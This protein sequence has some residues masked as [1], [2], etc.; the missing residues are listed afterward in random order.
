MSTS[1]STRMEE[2]MGIG[3]SMKY[4][5]P[6][7]EQGRSQAVLK[8]TTHREGST[9]TWQEEL[10]S[11]K[12][13]LVNIHARGATTW[14]Q[15]A[16]AKEGQLVKRDTWCYARDHGYPDVRGEPRPQFYPKSTVQKE[17]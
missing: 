4:G 5:E 1:T 11:A 16:R 17:G 9:P 15:E 10:G 2:Q 12:L 6:Q 8:C 13:E 3:T 7:I 14:T